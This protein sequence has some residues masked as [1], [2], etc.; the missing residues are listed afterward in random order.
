MNPYQVLGV[1]PDSS[2]DEIKKK[3]RSLI[4]KYHPDKCHDD[5]TKFKQIQKA[6]EMIEDDNIK[7]QANP[8]E[9]FE[10][11]SRHFT[12]GFQVFQAMMNGITKTNEGVTVLLPNGQKIFISSYEAGT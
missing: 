7:I 4:M 12:S 9:M 8:A 1:A 10:T 2:K 11:M 3:Y 6:F 5:G